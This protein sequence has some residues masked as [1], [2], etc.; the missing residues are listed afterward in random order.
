MKS[1]RD[2]YKIGRGP[3]SS[4]TMGPERACRLFRAE[5]PEA[6]RFRAVLFGS[7]AKTGPGHGSDRVIRE[8]FSPLP[9]EVVFDV[10]KAELKHPNTMD[11]F[12]LD[13]GGAGI[14]PGVLWDAPSL[15]EEWL[16]A[17]SLWLLPGEADRSPW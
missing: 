4:H 14:L 1:I 8:T 16:P 3:S 13:G 6:A 11:L 10:E 17:D 15:L 9:C 5:H 7:L 2:I 12:A